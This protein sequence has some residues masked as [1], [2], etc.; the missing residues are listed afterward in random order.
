[1]F[2]TQARS[3][4]AV[5]RRDA[6]VA[7]LAGLISARVDSLVRRADSLPARDR[8]RRQ[9]AAAKRKADE[10]A[11]LKAAIAKHPDPDSPESWGG[12]LSI[13]PASAPKDREGVRARLTAGDELDP[14]EVKPLPLDESVQTGVAAMAAA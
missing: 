4:E 8:R 5:Q 10:E 14:A 2:Q 6:A 3:D 1:M 7:E 11:S 13:H 9:D 12:A